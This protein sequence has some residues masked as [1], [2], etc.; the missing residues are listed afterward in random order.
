MANALSLL[1]VIAVY[2]DLTVLCL[3]GQ[4]EKCLHA[5]YLLSSGCQHSVSEEYSTTWAQLLLSAAATSCSS[6]VGASHVKLGDT[7]MVG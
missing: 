1:K 6:D 7:N 2:H 3:T 4:I 5:V